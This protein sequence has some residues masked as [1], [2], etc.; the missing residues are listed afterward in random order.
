M[1]LPQL[2]EEPRVQDSGLLLLVVEILPSLTI[3]AINVVAAPLFQIIVAVEDYP[4]ETE[5][6][7]TI[8]RSVRKSCFVELHVS[9]SL[10]TNVFTAP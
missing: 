6:A 4:P 5:V 10:L 3:T 2:L 9:P 7:V 8:A 1:C